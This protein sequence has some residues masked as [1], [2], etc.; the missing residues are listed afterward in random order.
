MMSKDHY[1][2]VNNKIPEVKSLCQQLGLAL[3]GLIRGHSYV[4]ANIPTHLQ[5]EGKAQ[6]TL[7]RGLCEKFLS[8]LANLWHEMQTILESESGDE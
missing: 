6:V 4:N 5:N 8:R 2:D 1:F 7:Y 3:E